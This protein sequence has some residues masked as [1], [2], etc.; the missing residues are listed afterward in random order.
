MKSKMTFI[1]VLIS[2]TAAVLVAVSCDKSSYEPKLQQSLSTSAVAYYV[3]LFAY[4]ECFPYINTL[5]KTVLTGVGTGRL[6]RAR[7]EPKRNRGPDQKPKQRP[8]VQRVSICGPGSR[9]S[10]LSAG[11]YLTKTP[12]WL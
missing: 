2:M 3:G 12:I 10:C 8:T 4:L 5:R 11:R 1:A 6:F 7:Q 9:K